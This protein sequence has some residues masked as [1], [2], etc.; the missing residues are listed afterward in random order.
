MI[1][2]KFA[3][4]YDDFMDFVDYNS[5]YKFLKTYINKNSKLKIA[6]LGCGT[7]KLSH[8]FSADGHEVHA[9]DISDD[10]LD[11]ARN[12]YENIEFNKIDITKN[13]VGKDYDFIMCNFDTVNYFNSFKEFINFL[14]LVYESLK[15]KGIFIFD[16]VEEGIFDEM[17][18]NDLFIDDTE[19]YTC[20]MKHDKKSK[21]KHIIDMVI[22][23]KEN[24][25]YNKYTEIHEKTIFDTDKIL[26]EVRK[27]GFEIYD[28]A[29]NSE[30]GESRIF[31]VC[32][33]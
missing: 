33:K 20:I 7:G 30:Y 18:E 23:A 3:H 14:K 28:S 29:R 19:E 12:K 32:K 21:F 17:F 13:S 8:L 31:L 24:G 22:F 26:E 11:I 1:H 15:E 10:M 5:W 9:F 4:I 2:K 25:V 6:D 16:F 27:I